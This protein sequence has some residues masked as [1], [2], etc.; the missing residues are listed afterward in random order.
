M[1]MTP[2]SR[3]HSCGRGPSPATETPFQRVDG[4]WKRYTD[5]DRWDSNSCSAEDRSSAWIGSQEAS[6]G[7]ESS[8]A[9][10]RTYTADGADDSAERTDPTQWWW[11][12]SLTTTA[13]ETAEA[14]D[15]ELCQG[16]QSWIA[17]HPAL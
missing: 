17:K 7:G 12:R 8:Q 2:T 13:E 5:T 14:R 15:G 6:Q 9:G 10:A 3:I 11:A 16:D 1:H 4:A